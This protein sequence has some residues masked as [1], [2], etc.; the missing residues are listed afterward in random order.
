MITWDDLNDS[1]EL[2][3][4]IRTGRRLTPFDPVPSNILD[5]HTAHVT[6]IGWYKIFLKH[7]YLLRRTRLYL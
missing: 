4:Y 1:K 5:S 7:R 6:A 2:T 3:F